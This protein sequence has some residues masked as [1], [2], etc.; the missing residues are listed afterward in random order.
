MAAVNGIATFSNLSINK[1]GGG[2]T[3]AAATAA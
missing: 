3:L 2:Y 1:V